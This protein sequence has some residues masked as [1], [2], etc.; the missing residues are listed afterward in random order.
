VVSS[1]SSF[2]S[3]SAGMAGAVSPSSRVSLWHAEARS[4]ARLSLTCDPLWPELMQGVQLRATIAL[5]VSF[6]STASWCWM[7]GRCDGA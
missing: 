7:G 4:L 5:P 1:F 6:C 2:S 3:S